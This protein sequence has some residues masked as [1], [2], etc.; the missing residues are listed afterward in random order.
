MLKFNKR[1]DSDRQG[2]KRLDRTIYFYDEVNDETVCEAT[3]LIDLLERESKTKPIEFIICSGGGCCYNGLAL[4]DKL[5]TSSCPII[6]K[7]TGII[8]SMA[9]SLFLAGDERIATESVRFMTHQIATYMEGRLSDAEIDIKETK[10]LEEILL[11]IA[12]ERTGL[13]VKELK[14]QVVI[15]DNYFTASDALA[16]GYAT[17]ILRNKKSKKSKNK[18]VNYDNN[19]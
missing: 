19:N 9:V 3:Y 7:G 10:Q 13:S 16:R 5:R 12:S 6:T 11:K 18:G 15:G 1:D 14:A 2:V 17:R 4:Y 8:A